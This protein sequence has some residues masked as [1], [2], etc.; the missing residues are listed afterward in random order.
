MLFA[1]VQTNSYICGV[2]FGKYFADGS[3]GVYSRMRALVSVCVYIISINIVK[4]I[5]LSK[6]SI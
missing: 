6:Y 3:G 5:C 2:V 1:S 4:P